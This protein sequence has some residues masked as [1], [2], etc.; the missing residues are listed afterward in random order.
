MDFWMVAVW[1]VDCRSFGVLDCY[2]VSMWQCGVWIVELQCGR[3]EYSSVA[4][5][6]IAVWIVEL[7]C[8]RV[9]Y[10]SVAG[11]RV[12]WPETEH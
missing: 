4:G 12:G 8:G 5:W 10:S 6:S 9:E 1:S 7:K 3:L 2:S 11:W